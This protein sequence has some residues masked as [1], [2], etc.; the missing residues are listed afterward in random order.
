MI[1]LIYDSY[2]LIL[3]NS[4]TSSVQS[5]EETDKHRNIL[6]IT[7]TVVGKGMHTLI[8]LLVSMKYTK[9]KN[10][11]APLNLKVKVY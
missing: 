4:Q 1:N 9:S 7:G 8:P 2:F 11:Y 3:T 10:K 5:S 6:Q